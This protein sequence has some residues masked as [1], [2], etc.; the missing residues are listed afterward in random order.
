MSERI[1]LPVLDI[2]PNKFNPNVMAPEEFESLKKGMKQSGP[3]HKLAVDRILVSPKNVFYKGPLMTKGYVIVDGENR[4]RA[5]VD[6]GWKTIPCEK[7]M[8]D[9]ALAKIMCYRRNKERGSLDP[10]KEAMLFKSEIIDHGLTQEDLATKYNI[11]RVYVANRLTLVKMDTRAIEMF[12]KPKEAFKKL[13]L[14][15]HEKAVEEWKEDT[16]EFESQVEEARAEGADEPYEGYW[17]RNKPQKPEEPTKEEFVPRGTMSTSHLEVIS[18]LP[19]KEQT[20]MAARVLSRGWNVRETEEKVKRR[21]EEIAKAERFAKALATAK[22][23]KCPGCGSD[24]ED[25]YWQDETKFKC[26][27]SGCYTNWDFS[28]SANEVAKEQKGLRTEE[29]SSRTTDMKK[30][31]KEA[32]ENPSYIRMK[33]TPQELHEKVAPYVLKKLKELTEL[34]SVKITGKR[35]NEL[36][37]IE[38]GPPKSG[39][40]RMNL[41]VRTS[42]PD[43]EGKEN[44]WLDWDRTFGFTVEEKNYKSI[45]A[46]SRVDLGW[47]S[48][49]SPEARANLEK[50]FAETVE[51]DKDPTFTEKKKRIEKEEKTNAE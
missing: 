22:R 41:A 9:E 49:P 40:H 1:N 32:R 2:E 7:R 35:G 24:P 17:E 8:I 3:D 44:R 20:L 14:G 21:K 26:P 16:K 10:V 13:V 12:R 36:I 45:D 23:K 11:S 30:R 50:F 33:E 47:P 27:K 34:T 5:A 15:A 31:F 38:Y 46:K 25:F 37:E 18:T 19:A 28:K 48:T 51:T 43:P 6:L 42:D 39:F 29:Q 4:W